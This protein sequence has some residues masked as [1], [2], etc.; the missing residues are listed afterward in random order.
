MKLKYYLRGVG[1]GVIV[2][3]LIMTVSSVVH[4]NNLST[5]RIMKEAK[6]L[7]MIMPE[8]E[9]EDYMEASSA[10][11]E[12]ATGSSDVTGSES[13]KDNES[14]KDSESETVNEGTQN[15]SEAESESEVTVPAGTLITLTVSP[16]DYARQVA[17]KLYASKLID[18]AEAFRVY[19]GNKGYG[20]RIRVGTFQIPMG[21]TYDE[22]LQII[23][24]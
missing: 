16:G 14:V 21:S 4:N 3:T 15:T 17:E 13:V 23:C 20:Q 24:F 10:E 18:D 19:L 12:D 22:I 8:S 9:T 2:A 5:E 7:G 6:K 11:D 1:L